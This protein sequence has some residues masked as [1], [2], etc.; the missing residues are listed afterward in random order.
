MRKTRALN[1]RQESRNWII[2]TTLSILFH[3][4]SHVNNL[5]AIKIEESKGLKSIH[6]ERSKKRIIP[7]QQ[8]H[9]LDIVVLLKR[10]HLVSNQTIR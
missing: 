1:S 6:Q 9:K 3:E 4:E 10:K 2:S 8:F 7:E 5:K